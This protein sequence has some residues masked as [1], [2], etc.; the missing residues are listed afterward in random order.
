MKFLKT[1]SVVGALIIFFISTPSAFAAN[2]A[3]VLDASRSPQLNSVTEDAGAPTGSVGTQVIS[4]VDFTIPAGQ[5]DN[6]TDGDGGSTGIA[7]TGVDTENV[8]CYFS[9]NNGVTWTAIGAVSNTSARLLL[10]NGTNRV[11]CQPA[12]N[13]SGMKA[14]VIT[15]RAWDGTSGIDGATADTSVTGGTS[16]FSTATDGVS[17]NII[18]VNDAPIAGDDSYSMTRNASTTSM[19][20]LDNDTD[21]DNDPLTITSV[22]PDTGTVGTL[23]IT[24]SNTMLHYYPANGFCGTETFTYTISDGNGATDTGTVTWEVICPTPPT[25]TTVT[26]AQGAT[27]QSTTVPIIITFSEPMATIGLTYGSSPCD[28]TCPTYSEEWSNSNQTLTLTP[29]QPFKE[30]VTYTIEITH[31]Y[32]LTGMGNDLVAP[33]VWS[34][35]TTAPVVASVGVTTSGRGSPW[36]PVVSRVPSSGVQPVSKPS[37]YFPRTLRLGAKG[38]DVVTLQKFLG[39]NPVPTKYF[40]IKTRA[41]LITYQAGHGLAAD[42]VLGAKSRAMIESELNK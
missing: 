19:A 11:Y 21:A 37:Y 15:F 36:G 33:Y 18:A 6:V 27:G 4:L 17:M 1:L 24:D 29:S 3:P 22:T 38:D 41:A 30:G 14:N 40:G 8:S 9:I 12:S 16:A 42:G 39:V 26:P 13:V 5:N 31:A 25:V 34:F 28:E 32:T 35:T 2:S 7:I 23:Q 10:A 20:V